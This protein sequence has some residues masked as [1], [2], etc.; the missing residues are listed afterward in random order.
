MSVNIFEYR[1][2]WKALYGDND[3]REKLEL[4]TIFVQMLFL[5][6]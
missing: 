6:T 1:E 3:P 4:S 5:T 2:G